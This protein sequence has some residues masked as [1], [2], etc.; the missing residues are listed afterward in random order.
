MCYILLFKFLLKLS[1]TFLFDCRISCSHVY[2]DVVYINFV[3]RKYSSYALA[4]YTS[5]VILRFT[6]KQ[7]HDHLMVKDSHKI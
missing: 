4:S 7:I 2:I 6:E 1:F 3:L 5:N